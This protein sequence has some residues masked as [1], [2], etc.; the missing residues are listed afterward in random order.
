M[1]IDEGDSRPAEGIALRV[2][3]SLHDP[4]AER[5]ERKLELL[6]LSGHVCIEGSLL[7]PETPLR[8]RLRP[9]C[10]QAWTP[11]FD[12]L[13]LA[14]RLDMEIGATGDEDARLRREILTAMLASPVGFEFPSFDELHACVHMRRNIA[15]AAARTALSFHTTQLERPWEC[16]HYRDGAGFL[17]RP[18][19]SLIEALAR[20]TQP[21]AGQ[22][23]YAFSC[24]RATEYV[25]LLGIAQQ[26]RLCNPALL[27]RLQ[28]QW[29]HSAIQSGRFHDVFLYEYGSAQA[30][31]PRHY[32]VPGDR[33]WFRNPDPV[34]SDASGFEGS[35]VFY[36]GEGLFSNFWRR[37]DPFTL[38]TKCVEIHHWRDADYVDDEGDRRIDEQ[39]VAA[40]VS[41]TMADPEAVQRVTD[42]MDR[43]ADLR[44]VY[45]EGGCIDRTREFPRRVCPFTED[46]VLPN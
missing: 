15:R 17:L 22:P 41:R 18:G 6:G 3:G 19:A 7:H 43:L 26:L 21:E 39:V 42:A 1:R 30:P 34:S 9:D 11:G 37:D 31:L 44:G 12:T 27:D 5:L 10:Q 8:I 20:A 35:W 45:A 13:G 4:G 36:L 46:I 2:S 14:R 28:R 23:L 29:M 38:T 32:Y 33:A 40:H 25:I 16:W 24:Y